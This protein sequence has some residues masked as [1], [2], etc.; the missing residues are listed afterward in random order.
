M[1]TRITVL[2]IAIRLRIGRLAVY[3]M[4]DQGIIPGVRLGKRWIV[5]RHAY[6]QWE[7]TCGLSPSNANCVQRH[8]Q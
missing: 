4:L 3:K 5:T 6:E 8:L 7:L 2:E 1:G